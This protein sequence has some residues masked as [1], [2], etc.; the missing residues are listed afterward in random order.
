MLFMTSQ[1]CRWRW[2]YT[3]R[4]NYA[5]EGRRTLCILM[6]PVVSLG[7][8]FT[9]E[10]ICTCSPSFQM[11]SRNKWNACRSVIS[12]PRGVE[13][14]ISHIG[15]TI[16]GTTQ[17]AYLVTWSTQLIKKLWSRTR[18]GPL[19]IRV[20]WWCLVAV[21][22]AHTWRWCSDVIKRTLNHKEQVQQPLDLSTQ[23]DASKLLYM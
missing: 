1:R 11:R 7:N 2:S 19:F 8:R 12:F 17:T 20:F 22:W 15:C 9:R 18:L 16:F 10:E 14:K 4:I 13:E 21:F 5:W 6:R 3:L 23:Q